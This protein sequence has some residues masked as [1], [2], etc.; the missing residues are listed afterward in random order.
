MVRPSGGVPGATG[1]SMGMNPRSDGLAL[2]STSARGVWSLEPNE[3]A[4][5]RVV[6]GHI[7]L[8]AAMRPHVPGRPMAR[9]E[10]AE[11]PSETPSVESV[12]GLEA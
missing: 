6:E 12:F 1:G 2:G 4:I 9:F 7:A 3:E 8:F 11:T 10:P 5:R